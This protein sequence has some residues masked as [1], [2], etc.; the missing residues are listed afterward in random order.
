[1]FRV[2]DRVAVGDEGLFDFFFKVDF[3]VH[4]V[5]ARAWGKPLI[6]LSWIIQG[7]IG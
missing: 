5:L 6:R 2:A 4:G 1:M 3:F 7:A